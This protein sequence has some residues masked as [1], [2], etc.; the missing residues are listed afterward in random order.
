MRLE[1]GDWIILKKESTITSNYNKIGKIIDINFHQK[2]FI[3]NFGKKNGNLSKKYEIFLQMEYR[4]ATES[5]I[6]SEKI[7]R[8]FICEDGK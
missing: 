7:K 5:E 1:I 2:V 3:I 6:K 4:L 8:I